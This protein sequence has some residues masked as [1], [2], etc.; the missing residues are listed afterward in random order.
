MK[1]TRACLHLANEI[2]T[3]DKVLFY[4]RVADVGKVWIDAG[5][6]IDFDTRRDEAW[7]CVKRHET[8][9]QHQS[10]LDA[11]HVKLRLVLQFIFL[12][13]LKAKPKTTTQ[14]ITN[15]AQAHEAS[16]FADQIRLGNNV[17]LF[18]DL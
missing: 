9:A 8:I 13:W 3:A 11:C 7:G 5:K 16:T 15:L 6:N 2:N 10:R 1:S 17:E 4:G 12:F 14:K 18:N